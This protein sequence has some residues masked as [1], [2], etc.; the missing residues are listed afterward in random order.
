MG[1]AERFTLDLIPMLHDRGMSVNLATFDRVKWTSVQRMFGQIQI[2]DTQISLLPFRLRLFGIYQRIL[3]KLIADRLGKRS[4][5]I[6]NTHSDH[7]FCYSDIVYMHGVTPLDETDSAGVFSRYNRSLLMKLYFYPYKRLILG[8][9][10]PYTEKDGT[11]FVANSR[12]TQDRMKRMLKINKSRVIYPAVDT[13]TYGLLARNGSRQDQV[14]TVGRFTR[15]K[16]LHRI[17]EIASKCPAN[18]KFAII[19][20]AAGVK[21]SLLEEFNYACKKFGVE[22]RIKLYMNISFGEKLQIIGNSK[23]YLHLMPAEHFGLAL[24]EAC[25]AGC[26]PVVVKGGGQEEIVEGVDHSVYDDL[27]H[28]ADLLRLAVSS[29]TPQK[30][31]EVSKLMDRFS[32]KNFSDQ[33]CSLIEEVYE[34]KTSGSIRNGTRISGVT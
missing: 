5:I 14:V 4:D 24:A 31:L 2:P 33:F 16:N 7:L 29:W 25:S 3:M 27:G 20:A 17:P 28:A 18:M 1:G 15:E 12:F 22:S 11:V 9:L 23:A 8:K 30:G 21:N 32:K 13:E 19:T 6:V 10:R 26:L 34:N